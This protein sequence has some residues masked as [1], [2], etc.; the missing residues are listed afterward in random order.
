MLIIFRSPHISDG[1]RQDDEE[2]EKVVKEIGKFVFHGIKILVKQS[3]CGAKV[4][5]KID[6]RK[7]GNAWV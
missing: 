4:R 5:K 1:K 2:G 3:I 6:I 7:R